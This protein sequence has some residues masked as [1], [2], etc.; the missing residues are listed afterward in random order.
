MPRIVFITQTWLEA[1]LLQQFTVF[2]E[3]FDSLLPKEEA[4]IKALMPNTASGSSHFP[5]CI[6]CFMALIFVSEIYLYAEG[7]LSQ[8]SGHFPNEMSRFSQLHKLPEN[9]SC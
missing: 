1:G 6:K 3:V 8:F 2:R 7:G 4:T 9:F 5:F